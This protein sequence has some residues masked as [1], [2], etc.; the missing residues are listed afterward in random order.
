MWRL[1][2]SPS[3]HHFLIPPPSPRLPQRVSERLVEGALV[4]GSRWK[5]VPAEGPW[6]PAAAGHCGATERCRGGDGR[7]RPQAS[8][9]LLHPAVRQR[10]RF[11]RGTI[12]SSCLQLGWFCWVISDVWKEMRQKV[13]VHGDDTPTFLWKPSN[14]CV[15]VCFHA[16]QASC[17][18]D[19]G[20]WLGVLFAETGSTTLPEE[21]HYDYIDVDTLTDIRH[22]A[23]NS[24]LWVTS[25]GICL[26]VS[27]CVHQDFSVCYRGVYPEMHLSLP[28]CFFLS[29]GPPPLQLPPAA[30]QQTPGRMTMSTRAWWGNIMWTTDKILH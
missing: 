9:L 6:R 24:F 17:S 22:A 12:L 11:S 18:E 19:L 14:V 8:L 7:P 20:R 29:D 15:C 1:H 30:P 26:C 13:N 16:H 23:R 25:C 4:R 28:L 21:L 27:A 5:P 10:T 2:V 3:F